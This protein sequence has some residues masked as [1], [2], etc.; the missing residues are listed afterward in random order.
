MD[1]HT[2]LSGSKLIVYNRFGKVVYEITSYDNTWDGRSNNG[3]PLEEEAYYYT[4]TCENQKEI[5]GAV[6]IIR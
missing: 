4:L 2:R 5:T 3:Q 6:R 1:K